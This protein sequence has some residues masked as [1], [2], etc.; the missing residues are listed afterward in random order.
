MANEM[1]SNFVCRVCGERHILPL[2]YSVKESIAA[3]AVP[4]SELEARVM[5][6]PDQCVIDNKE[7]FLRGRIPVLIHGIEEPLIW[8]VWAEISPKN[9]LRTVK[10]WKIAGRETEPA[11]PGYINSEIS[12]YGN[13]INLEPVI[14]FI[15]V[16]SKG[17]DGRST[18][19]SMDE[20]GKR[21]GAGIRAM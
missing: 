13:I 21:S 5:I 6:S 2:S 4:A 3:M 11:F 8:G 12:L 10:R 16:E 7:F 20:W 1:S 14:N 15:P 17:S 9:F 19:L 18:S